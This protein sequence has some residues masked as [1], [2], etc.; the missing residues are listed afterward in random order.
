LAADLL[1][2]ILNDARSYGQLHLPNSLQHTLD[3]PILQYADDTLTI[4]EGCSTQLALLKIL[5]QSLCESTGLKVNFSKSML[6]SIDIEDHRA[7]SLA[8]SFGCLV[9]SL[10]FTYLGLPSHRFPFSSKQM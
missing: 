5:L 1:Q 3:F 8:Q 6:V 4:I 2:N 9:V 10:S 7:A